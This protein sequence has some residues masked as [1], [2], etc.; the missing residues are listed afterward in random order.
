MRSRGPPSVSLAFSRTVENIDTSWADLSAPSTTVDAAPIFS[1]S[2]SHIGPGTLAVA[3]LPDL[4][5]PAEPRSGVVSLAFH[6]TRAGAA[7]LDHAGVAHV[8][9][10]AGRTNRVQHSFPFSSRKRAGC[11]CWSSGGDRLVT[12][13]QNGVFQTVDCPSQ[14]VRVCRLPGEASTITSISECAAAPLLAMVAGPR[15]HFVDAETLQTVRTVQTSDQLECG[16]FADG[17]A[18]F[19]AAGANGRGLLFKSETMNAVA[20]FQDQ[21]MQPIRAIA[22]SRGLV[23]MGTD[24]GVLEV[25]DFAALRQQTAR[26][27]FSKLNL[28]TA[29]NTVAFNPTGELLLFGSSG[30][31]ER[32]THSGSS[33][34]RRSQSS[35]IGQPSE[36]PSPSSGP[37][38]ST[39]QTD[40]S[41][42]GTKRHRNAVGTRVLRHEGSDR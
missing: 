23:A 12:G 13:G 42:S 31:R 4:L 28:T 36:H 30:L 10:V 21:D 32:R 5:R 34:S 37:P 1:D 25:F 29:I 19:V 16:C 15:V 24:A 7:V 22:A 39:Q 9:A 40:S 20:R 27:L 18:L 35:A 8:I 11:I 41:P 26:P 3:R 38:H 2:A 14:S 6:P 17:A 33:T